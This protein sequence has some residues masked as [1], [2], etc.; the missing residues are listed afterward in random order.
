VGV[1]FR[2]VGF[3]QVLFDTVRKR[4]Y[5]PVFGGGIVFNVDLNLYVISL[6]GDIKSVFG[7]IRTPLI[8]EFI[9][10][11]EFRH[12]RSLFAFDAARIVNNTFY[13]IVVD[14]AELSTVDDQS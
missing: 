4:F 9:A 12:V 3:L 8:W 13:G 6:D 10:V 2:V 14:D 7:F 11:T 5:E 1:I